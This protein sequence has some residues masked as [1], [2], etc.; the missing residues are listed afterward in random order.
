MPWP[1]PRKE[2]IK[3]AAGPGQITSMDSEKAPGGHYVE[4]LGLPRPN[5]PQ[6]RMARRLHQQEA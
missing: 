5:G 3:P 1:G 6:R 2:A 4:A